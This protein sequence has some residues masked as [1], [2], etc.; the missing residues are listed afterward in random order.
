MV[1][2]GFG[3]NC[4]MGGQ[5]LDGEGDIFL[6]TLEEAAVFLGHWSFLAKMCSPT[7]YFY[8]FAYAEVEI[9]KLTARSF[10]LTTFTVQILQFIAG[11]KLIRQRA[12]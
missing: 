12:Y 3:R 6:S 8:A 11:S 2:G 4:W 1:E 5:P 7:A 10:K 9:G